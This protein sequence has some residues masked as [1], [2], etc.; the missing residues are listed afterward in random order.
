[1][2]SKMNNRL[3][4]KQAN[5]IYRGMTLLELI[6]VMTILVALA[7]ILIPILNGFE[8]DV[9]GDG[10]VTKSP[11]QITTETTMNKIRDVVMGASA[12]PGVWADVAQRPANFPQS[13][14]D[15]FLTSIPAY[16]NISAFDAV[17][18]IGWRGPYLVSPT[19]TD[20]LGNG[21]LID[22]WGNP[23]VIQTPD[24]E[25]IYARIVSTG[26]NGVLETDP[27]TPMPWVRGDDIVVFFRVKDEI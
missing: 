18:R 19:G 24:A 26:S 22:S 9:F 11:E 2:D 3:T 25:A 6:V 1:M 14:S 5:E 12:R 7:G 15:L 20:G 4:T 10:A 21:T 8:I 16:M 13:V 23:I 27:G 17:T